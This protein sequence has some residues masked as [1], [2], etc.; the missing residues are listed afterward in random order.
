MPLVSEKSFRVEDSY[1]V[2][3]TP[4]HRRNTKHWRSGSSGRK[5]FLTFLCASTFLG[6]CL[7]YNSHRE[8]STDTDECVKPAT[9]DQP[10]IRSYS[11]TPGQ[12]CWPSVSEWNSFN[13]SISGNLRL[14]IPLA[15]PCYTNSSSDDCQRVAS[16]YGDSKV[17][18]S[19]YGAMEFL[20][21]EICGESQCLLN[22]LRPSLPVSGECSLGRLSTY[23]VVPRSAED[24]SQTL[25]FVRKHGIRVSIKNTGHDYFG[26]SNA[27]NSLAIWTHNMHGL[28]Y[29]RNFQPQGC[30][31]LYENI[32]EI[33]AG[34]QAQD[35]WTFFE[36]LGMLVTVGAVGSVG[37][38]GGY[39]QGGG[40]GPLGPKYGLMVDQA[41]EFEVVTADDEIRT[42]NECTDP[43]LFWAMRGGGG[44][45]YA[46]LTSYKFQLHPAVPINVYSFQAKFPKP[47]DVLDITESK[48]HRDIITALAHNQTLFSEHG[49]AGY[50]FVH[51]DK[52]VSLHVMPSA[53]TEAIK[54]VTSQWHDFL[55]EYPGLT[56]GEN[57]YYSFK[58]FSE[59][60]ELTETPEISRNGPVGLAIMGASRL[61][62]RE[63]F[64]TE[65]NV[66]KIVNAVLTA[67]HISYTNKAGGSAQLYSTGPANHPD[68]SKT[69]V[70]PAW[71]NALWH[72]FMGAAWISSTPPNVRSQ[73]QNTVSASIQPLKALTPGGGCYMNEG[74]WLEENWQQTFFG[75]N[76]DRLLHV[77]KRY[78]PTGLFNCW[79]CVGW[80][81]Y[82]E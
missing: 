31:T 38:A 51:K 44:G 2:Q 37:L 30:K 39:G 72:V 76:Y 42:I 79:K 1:I 11:C 43:D 48:V 66:E 50:N 28:I 71:R 3:E 49:I 16:S 41:V 5:R 10:P 7:V 68:N 67:M 18:S 64:S 62:P 82:D 77:K 61:I 46:V 24:I 54:T 65:Q 21:W 19:Q 9:S 75:D 81:G 29:H 4:I 6:S 20:N 27:A 70:N 35:A 33:G 40:H 13:Q 53:D 12:T 25:G 58:K 56:I 47:K 73:I 80:T 23:H 45:S 15:S 8:Y 69:G 36:R 26:R 74:D 59:W 55:S 17:R 63:M 78:D 52:I 34:I 60:H 57:K 22:S 14:T 32:G